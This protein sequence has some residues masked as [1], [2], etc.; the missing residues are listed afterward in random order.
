MEVN[1]SICQMGKI[2]NFTIET[3]KMRN[4]ENVDKHIAYRFD[5][6]N[7]C[8]AWLVATDNDYV[9]ETDRATILAQLD[10][11]SICLKRRW[12]NQAKS[13][14]IRLDLESKLDAA[15]ATYQG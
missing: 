5:G 1:N 14:A 8:Q 2:T 10:N 7:V 13:V 4:G 15:I 12:R 3:L 11:I 6:A 9:I